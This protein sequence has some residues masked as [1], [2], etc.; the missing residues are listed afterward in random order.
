VA[1]IKERVQT[2]QKESKEN[3]AS[4]Y[5]RL[6]KSIVD[7]Q[8]KIIQESEEQIQTVQMELTATINRIF[9]DHHVL[10]DARPED[11]VDKSLNLFKADPQLLM[12]PRDGYLSTIDRQGSGARR[13]LLWTAI[14][15]LAESGKKKDIEN[16][17]PH[18]LL[19]D[20]PEIC[21]HPNAIREACDL[22]YSLPIATKNWQVM[23]TTHSPC[24]VDFSRDHTTIVRVERTSEGDVIGT[25]IFRPERAHFTGDDKEQLKLLNMCDPYVAEFFFG[26]K[27]IIVEGDTEYTAFKSVALMS[28]EDFKDVHII[29]ARGK[30]TIVSLAKILNQFGTP[31]AILH[32]SDL[33]TYKTK[34]NSERAN[35][36][37][38][39]NRTILET[40]M[41]S[42][43]AV[44]VVASLV[45]FETAYLGEE[46]KKEKPYNALSKIKAENSVKEKIQQLF[47]ALLDFS[48]PLPEKAMEWKTLDEL[49]SMIKYDVK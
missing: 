2:H 39:S 24:F 20:E 44:R 9:P 31:Y 18:V 5:S 1:A 29:R 17:R 19:L 46:Y 10:F 14:R 22:L 32:D 35:P 30:A 4:D 43:A 48:K 47:I 49:Q 7:L 28:S 26:G 13:T 23:V 40:A 27:T 11:D 36:A 45:N 42:K 21:L 8:K 38:E 34:D 3:E 6:L 33:P 25:T 41:Q 37:W 16:Q 12:G 15:L